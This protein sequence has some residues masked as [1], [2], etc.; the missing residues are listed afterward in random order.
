LRKNKKIESFRE[1]KKEE[2]LSTLATGLNRPCLRKWC[3]FRGLPRNAAISPRKEAPI[4]RYLKRK[5]AI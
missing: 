4:A 3:G 5:P 1:E 2:T